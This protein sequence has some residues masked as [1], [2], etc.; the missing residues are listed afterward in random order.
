MFEAV[1]GLQNTQLAVPTMPGSEG[2]GPQSVALLRQMG[3]TLAI[4]EVNEGKQT[5]S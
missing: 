5:Q 2:S 3:Q 1:P 4:E